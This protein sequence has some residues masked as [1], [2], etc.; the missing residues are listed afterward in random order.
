[1]VG[2]LL[3]F[4]HRI[5]GAGWR[6]SRWR[7]FILRRRTADTAT[8]TAGITGPCAAH[9]KAPAGVVMEECV[10]PLAGPG[11]APK[12]RCLCVHSRVGIPTDAADIAQADA[13][14]GIIVIPAGCRGRV[15]FRDSM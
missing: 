15:G 14:K 1:M 8:P 5:L 4:L 3:R 11:A 6:R 13:S 7:T 12:S 2:A 10:A 9:A